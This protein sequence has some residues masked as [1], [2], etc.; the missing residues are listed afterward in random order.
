[1]AFFAQTGPEGYGPL[2]AALGKEL[3]DVIASTQVDPQIH[4]QR[5]LLSKS[6]DEFKRSTQG[7]DLKP[8]D[9]ATEFIKS[10]AGI[11]GSE[12]YVGQLLPLM[13]QYARDQRGAETPAIGEGEPRPQPGAPKG[14]K[15]TPVSP[16]M[17]SPM[18]TDQYLAQQDINLPPPETETPALFGP[19]LEPT[20]IGRGPLPKLYSP[21]QIQ[22]V[23][24]EDLKAGYGDSPRSQRMQEYNKLARDEVSDYVSAA[25]VHSQL[26]EARAVRQEQFRPFLQAQIG[27]TDSFDTALA[28][29][30][31]NEPR[32]AD[33][34]NDNIR[35]QKVAQEYNLLKKNLNNFKDAS[36]RPSPYNPLTRS[37]Y[38]ANFKTLRQNMQPLIDRGMRDQI[39]KTLIDNGWSKIEAEQIMNPLGENALENIKKLPSL[40]RVVGF[41]PTAPGSLTEKKKIKDAE[42]FSKKWENYLS[43]NIKPGE[44]DPRSQDVIK[45]G[46][47][48][49]LLRNEFMKKGGNWED[50][51]DLV[52][53][54]QENGKLKLDR[55]QEDEKN[56]II[57]RPVNSQSI[58]EF[59]FGTKSI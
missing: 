58:E 16:D 32:F 52:V 29:N 3:G 39:H 41:T 37:Q 57:Q 27:S 50:F 19:E 48:L 28:E 31:A 22:Q 53:D 34:S 38:E 42:N 26:G 30:I 21:E 24:L 1:M 18:T 55:F 4:A 15:P 56:I 44:V 12:K 8:V 49:L 25:K 46:T 59:F 14:I 11:P 13:I 45:P 23:T 47:S 35:A 7:K 20:K 51:R 33:I 54:L 10:T 36:Q 40:D 17:K 9:I 43:K 6:L 2:G 5:R